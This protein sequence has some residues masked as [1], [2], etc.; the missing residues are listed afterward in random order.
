MNASEAP[1]AEPFLLID[2]DRCLGC[3]RCVELCPSRALRVIED[4]ARVVAPSCIGCDHC[5]AACPTEAIRVNLIAPEA[6]HFATFAQDE[7]PLAPGAPFDADG[8]TIG[9][10]ARLMRSRRSC[11]QFKDERIPKPLL[12]DLVKIGAT[13]PSGTNSQR[14]TFTVLPTRA[15]VESAAQAISV[16]FRKLNRMAE[17]PW[18][19]AAMRV[20]GKPELAEYRR[21]YYAS[22]QAALE[23]YERN[24]TD[25][26]F[27]GAPAA[28]L[29]GSK[30]G[31]SC[32]ME[33]ALLATQNILLGAHALGLGSCLIGYAVAAMHEDKTIQ[34][35]LDIPKDEKIHAVIALGYPN[36]GWERLTG[37]KEIETRWIAPNK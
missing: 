10:L 34:L 15:A 21:E 16:F 17:K 5:A 27:H 9:Q 24:G 14:W 30:P 8:S 33:D 22:V 28:I 1:Q 37:R 20:L 31:A 36:Q 25:K 2:E 6:L 13:A 35:G 3:G 29:V 32:P 18:L 23:E 11:R 4:K 7:R 19:C 12:Q 26:L